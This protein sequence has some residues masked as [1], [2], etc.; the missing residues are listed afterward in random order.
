MRALFSVSTLAGGVLLLG[1][2]TST[3]RAHSYPHGGSFVL[4]CQNGGNYTLTT[5][6]VTA[7]GDVVTGH[8]QLS[9]RRRV[10]VRLMPMGVGYRYA[11]R[12]VWVD[13]IRDNALLYLSKYNPIP[14]VVGAA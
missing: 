11:G 6:P 9:P 12:G 2:A 3:A 1:I 10:H 4:S 14:C 7:S 8:L 5:G 13:G